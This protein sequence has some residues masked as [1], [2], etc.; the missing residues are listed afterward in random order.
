MTAHKISEMETQNDIEQA[1]ADANLIMLSPDQK[2]DLCDKAFTALE[3]LQV[4]K[5]IT[6][7]AARNLFWKIQDICIDNIS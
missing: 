2:A 7:D 4:E 6:A 5:S 3:R 1:L